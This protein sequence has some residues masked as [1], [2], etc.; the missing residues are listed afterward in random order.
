[1]SFFMTMFNC[2]IPMRMLLKSCVVV[3]LASICV[4]QPLTQR[5][6][7]SLFWVTWSTRIS[8]CN[9]QNWHALYLGSHFYHWF[10]L[11]PVVDPYA[12]IDL[13]GAVGVGAWT[14]HGDNVDA[15]IYPIEQM[16]VV[17]LGD[18]C[19]LIWFAVL[20][21]KLL[22]VEGLCLGWEFSWLRLVWCDRKAWSWRTHWLQWKSAWSAVL[23]WFVGMFGEL[24]CKRHSGSQHR[25]KLMAEERLIWVQRTTSQWWQHWCQQPDVYMTSGVR[26]FMVLVGESPRDYPTPL[27][28]VALCYSRWKND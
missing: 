5:W 7:I 13:K 2:L 24:H 17:V 10:V 22:V 23:R 12:P 1:M 4:T 15:G 26:I 21:R 25:L 14:V 3:V 11:L 28:K 9:F 18:K 6:W 16:A 20:R 8:R 19:I 27:S